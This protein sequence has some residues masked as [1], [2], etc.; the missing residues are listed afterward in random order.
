MPPVALVAAVN[1]CLGGAPTG[2][3]TYFR[4]TAQP[5]LGGDQTVWIVTAR[6]VVTNEATAAIQMPVVD[7]KVSGTLTLDIMTASLRDT[8][9]EPGQTAKW[10][11]TTITQSGKEPTP[12]LVLGK[13]SWLDTTIQGRC[14]R[15]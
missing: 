10:E 9:L 12:A 6:G 13:W 1:P 14:A 8:S 3:I 4:A 2:Q 5:G 15:S 7:I 11:T